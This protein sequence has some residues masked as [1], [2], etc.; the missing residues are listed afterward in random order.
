MGS[1]IIV[2][3]LFKR[4]RSEKDKFPK[5]HFEIMDLIKIIIYL[6]E[7]KRKKRSDL[8][9]MEWRHFW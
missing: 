1:D 3:Q 7:I 8:E 4:H 9:I 5:I 6:V 2:P